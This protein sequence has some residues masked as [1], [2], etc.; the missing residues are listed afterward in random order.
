[1]NKA[2]K[3][4][5]PKNVKIEFTYDYDKFKLVGVNRST[6]DR[7]IRN[8]SDSILN[9]NL[10]HLF[11]VIVNSKYEIMDGQHRLSAVKNILLAKEMNLPVYY[12]MDPEITIDDISLLNSNKV[13][14]SNMDYVNFYAFKMNKNYI[15]ILKFLKKHPWAKLSTALELLSSHHRDVQVLKEGNFKAD[16]EGQGYFVATCVEELGKQITSYYQF[17]KGTAFCTAL[18]RMVRTKKYDH[19][20][21]L[22]SKILANLEAQHTEREFVHELQ[23]IYNNNRKDKVNFVQEINK[24]F[25]HKNY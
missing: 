3:R 16:R 21:M 17:W 2:Q 1:M 8:I 6:I 19:Q 9:R 15:V 14:W 11:P 13:N 12:I 18:N 10:L 20:V 4:V 23:H 25:K 24:S 5:P 22:Q 7:H